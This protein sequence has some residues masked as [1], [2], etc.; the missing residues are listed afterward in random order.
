VFRA[1]QFTKEGGIFFGVKSVNSL[2]FGP[3]QATGRPFVI[4]HSDLLGFTRI[5]PVA[6]T[7]LSAAHHNDRPSFSAQV[8]V[9]PRNPPDTKP[10]I[11]SKSPAMLASGSAGD[12]FHNLYN[13]CKSVYN[14]LNIHWFPGKSRN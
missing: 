7:L 11:G 8:E 10:M 13:L 3:S 2:I 12:I 1:T 14:H 6:A 5:N 4:F 9:R